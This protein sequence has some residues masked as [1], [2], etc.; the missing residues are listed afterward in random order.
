MLKRIPAFVWGQ[1]LGAFVTGAVAGAFLDWKAVQLFSSA[2][3]ANA[4]V[5]SLI[6]W[7]W[8]GFSAAW[9]K[10]WLTATFANPLMLGAI[11]WSV[12]YWGCFV[13]TRSGWGCLF[14]DMGRDVMVLCLPAPLIGLAA[15]WWRKRALA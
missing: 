2:L 3:A 6:C 4:V 8:P 7:W 13:G 15:R 12:D 5:T 9:W 10:L 14:Y 11:A 1:V